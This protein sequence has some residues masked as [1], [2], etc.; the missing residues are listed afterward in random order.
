MPMFK[1]ILISVS[2]LHYDDL[3]ESLRNNENVYYIGNI[4]LFSPKRGSAIVGVYSK[5]E[6]HVQI[7]FFLFY[8]ER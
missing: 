7:V 8:V 3:L 6:E 1:L 5:K 2:I 4:I